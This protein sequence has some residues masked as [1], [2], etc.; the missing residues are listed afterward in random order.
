MSLGALFAR[1]PQRMELPGPVSVAAAVNAALPP[2]VGLRS[3]HNISYSHG[4]YM[5]AAPEAL[6]SA[7]WCAELQR[8]VPHAYSKLCTAIVSSSPGSSLSSGR[9]M[10]LMENNPVVAAFGHAIAAR[11]GPSLSLGRSLPAIELDIYLDEAVCSA[12]ER[13]YAIETCAVPEA[14][15]LEDLAVRLVD[16]TLVAHGGAMHV[17]FERMLG[18]SVHGAIASRCGGMTVSRWLDCFFAALRGPAAISTASPEDKSTGHDVPSDNVVCSGACSSQRTS[19]D[20]L[21]APLSVFL[22]VKSAAATPRALN[23][24]VRGF[25]ARGV[26]VWGVGSFL[27]HQVC[28]STWS[29]QRVGPG[30]SAA[31]APIPFLLF[32][33]AAGIQASFEARRL[34]RGSHILFNG[35]SLLLQ[36]QAANRSASAPPPFVP[37]ALLEDLGELAVRADLHLG[38]YA[39]EQLLCPKAAE[40][41]SEVADTHR[42]HFPHGFAY[43]GVPGRASGDIAMHGVGIRR[44][45]RVVVWFLGW[46]FGVRV[47]WKHE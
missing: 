39:A 31:P 27:H 24:L 26:H 4:G 16:T 14:G 19:S 6:R 42:G 17:F 33:H 36:P 37:P 18:V 32:S 29:E 34:P 44:L 5:A 12:V 1:A 45:P 21:R 47:E 3:L 30:G 25:N 10:E 2:S 41:L 13:A 43:S 15:I 20:L 35:G 28:P 38:Y 23:L 46:L 8:L 40:L 7:P 11:L 9:L 22:D